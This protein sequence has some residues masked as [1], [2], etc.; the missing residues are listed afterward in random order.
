[1]KFDVDDHLRAAKR[2]ASS[3]ERDGNL[4]HAVTLVRSYSTTIEDLWD[5]VTNAERLPRWFLPI[6]GDLEP[7]GRYE[8]EGNAS[9][10]I[11][12]CEPPTHLAITWEF[13]GDVSWLDIR[14]SRDDAGVTHLALTHTAL[15]SEHWAEYGP[16]AVGVGWELAALGLSLYLAQPTA[17][18]P[19]EAT[20]SASREGKSFIAGSSEGWGEAAVASGMTPDAARVACDRTTAFYTG[21][22]S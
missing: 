15:D 11:T 8:L 3:L 7:G 17:P 1:M 5:A 6:S 21:E 12:G 16:G 10:V 22:S 13:G 14:L 18:K 2:C 9:G 20:F 19:D 4:A